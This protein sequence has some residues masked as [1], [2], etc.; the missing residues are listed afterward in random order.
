MSRN[1]RETNRRLLRHLSLDQ[2]DNLQARAEALQ[3]GGDEH[4]VAPE[5]GS[6]S[7]G[8]R[9]RSFPSHEFGFGTPSRTAAAPRHR[10]RIVNL[11]RATRRNVEVVNEDPR[12]GLLT[13]LALVLRATVRRTFGLVRRANAVR[14]G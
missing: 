4:F 14:L 8:S 7:I 10:M 12:P 11:N 2:Q 6:T 9:P 5:N 13:R 1:R 3:A